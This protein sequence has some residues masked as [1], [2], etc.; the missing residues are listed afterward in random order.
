MNGRL[1]SI[2]ALAALVA[3]L[4]MAPLAR[5]AEES[6]QPRLEAT[7]TEGADA[8][9]AKSEFTLRLGNE[10]NKN[11]GNFGPLTYGLRVEHAF[12]NG[13]EVEA[14]YVLL[15]EPKTP[16]SAAAV[17][18]AQFTFKLPETR[19]V[20][21]PVVVG[22]TAWKNRMID[23]Y[24]NVGGVEVTRTGDFAVTAGIYVG[25]ATREEL[26]RRFVGGQAGVSGSIGPIELGASQMVGSILTD[27]DRGYYRKTAVEAAANL[28]VVDKLPLQLTFSIE[29]RYFDFGNEQARS[30]PSDALIFVTGIEVHFEEI[31]LPLF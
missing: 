26:S 14:G 17:D 3:H 16:S 29:D 15:H 31:L 8:P 27:R 20:D 1:S 9:A 7:P 4:L 23:M 2:S 19:L 6:V 13:T 22:L 24:T 18:E 25:S 5:A 12:S 30:D 10:S 21:Q 11:D 28:P